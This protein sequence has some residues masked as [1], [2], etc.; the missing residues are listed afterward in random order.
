[1]T[2]ERALRG[3]A[4]GVGGYRR[5]EPGPGEAPVD[6]TD[7]APAPAHPGHP[8]LTLAHLSDIHVCDA[9]SPARVEF[10]DRWADPDSPV[11]DRLGEVGAYR[12]QEI[13]T[14]QVADAMVQAV[15]A[16][17]EGPV[18]GGRLDLAIATGDNIDNSQANELA[19]YVSLLDGGRVHPDSGDRARY[20]GVADDVGFDERYWHPESATPDR[21]RAHFGF[22]TV[23]GLLDAARAPFD[24]AGLAVPWLAVHGNHD[25]MMQ[26]TV[27]GVGPLAAVAVGGVKPVALPAHLS[28]DEV[29]KLIAGLADC[30]PAALAL[31]AEAELRAVTADAGRRVISRAD[32]VAAHYSDRARPNGHGFQSDGRPYYR[33]DHYPHGGPGDSSD[34]V[35]LLVLDTVDEYGGWQGSLDEEQGRWL[36][37][38]LT[39]ADAE[40][41]Y[42]VLASHHP[43]DTL[44]N[45][46]VAD[47]AAPR[48]LGPE[49]AALLAGHPSLVLWLNGHSHE[50]AVAARGSFWEVTAPSLIDWPQQGRIVEVLR[51][52]GGLTIAATMLDHAGSAPWAGTVDGTI[53]LAGLS[54]ELAANDW[55]WRRG[56]LERQPRAGHAQ[57]RNVRLH[58][59][60]PWA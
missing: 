59:R 36:T 18:G 27:P 56:G 32:F 9:Q 30:D 51:G 38:E 48:I 52:D 17:T 50:T 33:Y 42:V 4:E 54:R 28:T 13:L 25:Q 53:T 43:L 26:G 14:T 57:S 21:P 45:D 29:V 47:G 44:V 1:M 58:L 20:E 55:Q 19:W 16:V 41:R 60:D 37:D 31:L 23:P 11:W 5:L 24:A 8:L 3:G 15:N 46:T 6:R 12:A 7:L 22:P 34:G 2:T 49:F 10:L 40:R 35:T 39:L